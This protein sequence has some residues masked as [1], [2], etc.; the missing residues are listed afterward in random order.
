MKLFGLIF[1]FFLAIGSCIMVNIADARMCDGNS[2]VEIE[3]LV[4]S[5]SA[6][7]S[8]VFVLLFLALYLKSRIKKED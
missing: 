2:L 8:G 7:V 3:Y 1:F 4:F 5:L 6:I